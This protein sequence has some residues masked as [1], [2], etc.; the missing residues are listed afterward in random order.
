MQMTTDEKQVI[1]ILLYD[2]DSIKEVCDILKPEMFM[3]QNCKL[4]YKDILEAHLLHEPMNVY[5]LVEKYKEQKGFVADINEA[6]GDYITSVG[7]RETAEV[8][9]ERFKKRKFREAMSKVGK[10]QST[11]EMA[12]YMRTFL[13][14]FKD[15]DA[16]SVHSLSEIA[17]Q[18]EDDYFKPHEL[19]E[20]GFKK[21]DELLGGL[22]R[23]D[24]TVIGARPAV[25]K[26]A[27]TLQLGLNLAKQKYKVGFFNLEMKE[28]QIYERLI[29]TFSGIPIMR[30]RKAFNFLN[31]EEKRYHEAVAKVKEQSLRVITRKNTV[32]QIRQITEAC[33]YDVIIID[34]LQLV[35]ASDRYKGNRAS[36]VAEVSA[37]FKRL[38]MDLNCHVILLSQL[39]RKTEDMQKPTMAELRESGAIEQDASNIFVMWNLKTE[40]EKGLNIEKQ[41]QGVLGGVV[42]QFDGDHMTFV[43]TDKDLKKEMEWKT[44]HKNPFGS[45]KS[46]NTTE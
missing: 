36:E 29:A 33:E 40:G 20:T 37:E 43:E 23:G 34:Y 35:K 6:Y 41:R 21:M 18:F 44:S 4:A 16:Q 42:F 9:R 26:S 17:E 19:I 32:D 8:I 7:I 31:D 30:I 15:D 46:E 39:N 10:L 38:A 14:D 1:G 45:K 12:A 28:K 3:D 24:I 2:R 5:K 22:D 25:G 27:F 11:E 13:A